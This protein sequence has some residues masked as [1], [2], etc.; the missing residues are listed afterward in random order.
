M[1]ELPLAKK[2][3][4]QHWL[5]DTGTL[6]AICDA[7]KVTAA[8]AV[9]EVGPGTGTLTKLLVQRAKQVIAVEYDPR[10]AQELSARVQA[11]NL[12]IVEQD[13]LEYDLT[14][15][16]AD[17][18]VVANIPYYLTSKLIRTLSETPNRA[19]RV[20]LLIQKEVAE[21]VAA[22][23][24]DMSL[25]SVSAQFY[26]DVSLGPIVPARMFTPAPKVDSQVLVLVRHAT[27]LYPD[28]D[29][30]QFF[31]VV[32]AGFSARRKKL[33][34]S[35]S[36]GLRISKDEAASLLV[37]AGINPDLRPQ[38]LSVGEWYGLYQAVHKVA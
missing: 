9:L 10:L 38:E 31:R 18:K 20:V 24:G 35:I 15:L 22:K 12:K 34:S 23:P 4:G 8:D 7:G 1:T 5:T 29:T 27:P 14:D 3:L 2:S 13:I 17:Y 37:A 11:Q 28:A 26:W 32:K 36:G 21:R 16:P 6:Q 30:K 33:R 25:L 19:A